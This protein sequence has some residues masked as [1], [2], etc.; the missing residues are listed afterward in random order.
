MVF[1][2][3]TTPSALAPPPTPRFRHAELAI[4]NPPA[5]L[6][7]PA[8][9][10]Q[11]QEFPY[12]PSTIYVIDI[13]NRIP[14]S[15]PASSIYIQKEN[16]SKSSEVHKLCNALLSSI[17]TN[18]ET[19][20]RSTRR[21]RS[22]SNPNYRNVEN[23]VR[24]RKRKTSGARNGSKYFRKGVGERKPSRGRRW[25]CSIVQRKRRMKGKE[26][27]GK[28]AEEAVNRVVESFWKYGN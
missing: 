10:L 11:P 20:G 1:T 9:Q 21:M 12:V 28:R 15:P 4:R 5:T 3:Q 24:K 18:G 13:T 23:R 26:K 6:L 16:A 2:Y 17:P 19:R 14:P 27:K 8:P 7:P 25:G 22:R